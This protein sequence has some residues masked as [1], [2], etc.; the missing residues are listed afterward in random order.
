ML[1]I[2]LKKE[3]FYPIASGIKKEYRIAFQYLQ[4]VEIKKLVLFRNGYLK[5]SPEA[6][7]ELIDITRKEDIYILRLG[8]VKSTNYLNK[9]DYRTFLNEV[10]KKVSLKKK[11]HLKQLNL[12]NNHYYQGV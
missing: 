3:R 7:V 12:F 4:D 1:N 8:G 10:E 6:V 5:G 11:K 9:Q 2:T